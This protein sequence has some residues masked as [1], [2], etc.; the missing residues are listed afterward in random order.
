MSTVATTAV[1]EA[2]SEK[3]DNLDDVTHPSI[4]FLPAF[5]ELLQKAIDRGSPL[6]RDEVE[7]Q[8]GDLAWDW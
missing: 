3:F 7:S 8:F 2:Y 5:G 1:S 6:T 4:F